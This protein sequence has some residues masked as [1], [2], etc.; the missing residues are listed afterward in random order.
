MKSI[1]KICLLMC[2]FN[3]S[4]TFASAESNGVAQQDKRV[5]KG[6]VVDAQGEAVIGATVTIAG[7]KSG[8]TITDFDGR[9]SIQVPAGKKL[10]VSYIGYVTQIVS[11]LENPRIV[12]KEDESMLDDVVVVGYGSLKQKNVTGAV[13]VISPDELKDLSV[14]SLSEALIGISPSLHIDMPSTG[15]PGENATITVRQAK[16]AVALVPT[17][18]DAGGMAIGGNSNP[19]PLYVIYDFVYKE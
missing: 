16:D 9:F 14:G 11:D 19:A 13:E 7:Q 2:L 12:L 3:V 15:R 1:I 6:T 4:V 8:G 17:G 5:V 10:K 18:K